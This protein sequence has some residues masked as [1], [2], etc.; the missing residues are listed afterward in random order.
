MDIPYPKEMD[1]W[2]PRQIISWAVETYGNQV[3]MSSSFQQQSLALLHMVSRTAPSLPVFFVDTGYHFPETLRFKARVTRHFG[4][5]VIE[6]PP[7]MRHEV[8]EACYGPELW[9]HNPDL[10]CY[11]NKVLPMQNAL[12][13]YKAW[14]TGIR[15]DQSAHRATA[16]VVQIRED[17]LIKVNPLVAW[18][19]TDVWHYIEFHRLPTHPLYEKGYKSIGCAPCTRPVREGEDERAGRWAE[20]KKT[21]CGLHTVFRVK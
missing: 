7:A 21:E 8:Q 9:K 14:I 5:R 10:C 15:R 13:A 18:T 11:L 1:Q 16:Q 6:W 19:R 17:G 2:T 4:L 3:A 12:R 20:G